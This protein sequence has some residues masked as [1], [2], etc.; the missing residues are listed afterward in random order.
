MMLQVEELKATASYGS[1]PTCT[2]LARLVGVA[3]AAR[4]RDPAAHTAL[5]IRESGGAR[6]APTNALGVVRAKDCNA[7]GV[8]SGSDS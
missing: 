7:T 8:I 3:L 5:P 2:S 1:L 4:L 6:H